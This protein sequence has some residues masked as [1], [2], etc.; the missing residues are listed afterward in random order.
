MAARA[1]LFLALIVVLTPPLYADPCGM[2]PPILAGTAGSIERMG[3][4]KTYVFYKDGTETFVIRPGYRGSVDN[5]G[6]LIPFPTPPAIRKVP[7]DIFTHIAAAADPP[8]VIVHVYK[9]ATDVDAIA[10]K[11]GIVVTGDQLHARAGRSSLVVLNQEAVGMYEVA[12]L[13][14]GSAS[15]LKKWMGDHGYRYPDGMDDVCQEYVND[16]WCFVAVKTR[17]GWKPGVDPRPGQRSVDP[18]LPS[19]ASFDG[20]VQAMGFRF[21]SD[22]LVVPM[23]LSA[24]N[25]GDPRNIVYVL[26]EEPVR[27]DQFSQG[28]VMRQV[29]GDKLYDNLTQP[30]P[31]RLI[32]DG[33][34]ENIPKHRRVGLDAERDPTPRNGHALELFASDLQA[35]RSN[36]LSH[37]FETSEKELLEIG[38]RLGLRGETLD[39]Y[40]HQALAEQKENGLRGALADIKHMTLTVMDGDFWHNRLARYNLTFSAY[41]GRATTPNATARH[42]S[43]AGDFMRPALSQA[44][45][46]NNS[47]TEVI[48]MGFTGTTS[49]V[50]GIRRVRNVESTHSPPGDFEYAKTITD[51]C[52]L[53][54]VDCLY[55]V[56]T[57]RRTAA[58]VDSRSAA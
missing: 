15:A 40:H 35:V 54:G 18:S 4:Q 16:G 20:H 55:G 34:Y 7:D 50:S 6:M 11:T 22:E 58:G 21:R 48:S 32:G 5:F 14:A 12:V 25:G 28:Y 3:L 36:R 19:G 24:F 52:L 2:V 26:S 29:V 39:R 43:P 23:R 1:A 44:E 13:Q 53:P 47:V 57:N 41:E 49:Y 38:E 37:P 46:C 45:G 17:V 10:L 33:G 56:V 8:E 31:L 30:L 27:V 9:S 51:S 42:P